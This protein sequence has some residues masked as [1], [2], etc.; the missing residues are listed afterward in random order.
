MAFTVVIPARYGSTRLPGKALLDIAGKPMVEH[1][2][3]RAR[4]SRAERVV[5]ATDD[6]RIVAAVESFG[7]EAVMTS[8]EHPS[9]TDRIEEVARRLGLPDDAQVVNVQGDEPLIP[10]AVID[11]VA[12]NLARHSDAGIATLCEPI[13]SIEDFLNPNIVKLV[14]DRSGMAL[15]FSRAP[16][17]WDRDGFAG[18]AEQ[19]AVPANARRHLGIYAYRVALLRQ[20]VGWPPAELERYESLE[21]LR[22][23]ANGARIHVADAVAAVPPGVDTAADL[24]AVRALVSGGS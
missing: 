2:Y 18:G 13:D 19:G 7:G 11:Q 9:G 12:D 6:E 20:F 10:A 23:L 17:P 5:V 22:A 1:V 3:Q 15:Y 16:I 4:E 21:Q 14:A 8:A 24:E